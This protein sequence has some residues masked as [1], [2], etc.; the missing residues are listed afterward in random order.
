MTK[1]II[2]K[3]F[4]ISILLLLWVSWK[5]Y[6]LNTR[7][8][9]FCDGV[10]IGWS[11]SELQAYASEADPDG[12]AVTTTEVVPSEYSLYAAEKLNI[13]DGEVRILFNRASPLRF[14]CRIRLE[15]SQVVVKN[16]E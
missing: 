13:S 11:L 3:V 12:V 1:L 16:M 8:S 14:V 7:A 4:L 15:N 5:S 2:M 10:T 9:R 6:D